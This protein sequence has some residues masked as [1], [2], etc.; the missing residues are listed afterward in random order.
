M[1]NSVLTV[2]L[3][4]VLC[5]STH[6]KNYHCIIGKTPNTTNCEKYKATLQKHI[7]K[8]EKSKVKKG[9]F[10]TYAGFAEKTIEKIKKEL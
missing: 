1:K 9:L 6:A 7:S 3:F 10:K 8:L 5:S 2:Y 4:L